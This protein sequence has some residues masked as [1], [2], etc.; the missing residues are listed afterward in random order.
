MFETALENAPVKDLVAEKR[1]E[2]HNV[3]SV[4]VGENPRGGGQGRDF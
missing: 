3:G 1:Q 2:R 4:I